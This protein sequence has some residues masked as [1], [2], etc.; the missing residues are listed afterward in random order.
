MRCYANQVTSKLLNLAAG[1]AVTATT[2]GA[3]YRILPNQADQQ[4][5]DLQ[6]FRFVTSLTFSGGATSPTAQVVI[7]GSVDNINWM[8]LASG[9]QRTTAGTYAE[10]V[11]SSGVALL[12]YVRARFVL[13]G[14]TAPSV[15]GTVD[16]I[17]NGPFQLSSP[18]V[19]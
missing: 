19:P 15:Y 17:S 11:E 10:V 4:T 18:V 9:T 7:Q 8:D 16:V 12:P 5:D 13:G 1:A 2:N 6:D 3:S 14:G